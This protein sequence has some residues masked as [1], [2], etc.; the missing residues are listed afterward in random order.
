MTDSRGRGTA[1]FWLIVGTLV[2][3]VL[4]LAFVP[5]LRPSG[6]S[7]KGTKIR[8]LLNP[9]LVSRE[10]FERRLPGFVADLAAA[11]DA[12]IAADPAI[13]L[14]S[15]VGPESLTA[16]PPEFKFS[17]RVRP[18]GASDPILVIEVVAGDSLSIIVTSASHSR[19]S[20]ATTVIRAI[21]GDAPAASI[22]EFHVAIDRAIADFERRYHGAPAPRDP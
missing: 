3:A 9:E 17:R 8:P 11:V 1:G 20:I 15:S 22:E 21:D 13:D 14:V 19:R 18:S 16:A 5:L 6:H 10:E 4:A 7:R 12:A 2:V